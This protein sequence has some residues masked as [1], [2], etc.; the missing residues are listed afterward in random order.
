M[1]ARLFPESVILR[2]GNAQPKLD[3]PA[4]VV[5]QLADAGVP[6]DH[7][8]TDPLC[9]ICN[10]SLFHSYRRDGARAG[11]MLAVAFMREES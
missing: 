7:I 8:E 4:A 2:A 9:T 5:Q 3:L 11:R 6:R 10:P 1:V